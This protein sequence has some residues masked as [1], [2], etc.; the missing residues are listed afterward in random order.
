[1]IQQRLVLFVF[2]EIES[3][4]TYEAEIEAAETIIVA[5]PAAAASQPAIPETRVRERTV[6]SCRSVPDTRRSP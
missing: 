6:S 4:V 1:M 2:V 5:V 3:G